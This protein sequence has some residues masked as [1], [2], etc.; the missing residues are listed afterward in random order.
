[1]TL[2]FDRR[3]SCLGCQVRCERVSLF[4]FSRDSRRWP[5]WCTRSQLIAQNR[6]PR[7][8]IS[9]VSF[10]L[11][12]VPSIMQQSRA[13][14]TFDNTQKYDRNDKKTRRGDIFTL[15]SQM[16]Q[17]HNS[18]GHA[19]NLARRVQWTTRCST[20]CYVEHSDFLTMKGQANV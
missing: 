2:Y 18:P 10:Y 14:Y 8:T 5:S 1:M 17:P 12:E 11:S 13:E 7:S 4:S 3:N 15:V 6:V 9:F 16:N 19:F 20:R